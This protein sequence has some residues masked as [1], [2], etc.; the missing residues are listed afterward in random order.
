MRYAKHA[1]DITRCS[2]N[3]RL[4][5]RASP[6]TVRSEARGT[7]SPR[8]K[9]R[10]WEREP[11]RRLP[12]SRRSGASRP[13][14]VNPGEVLI[15]AVNR[16]KP[17]MLSGLDQKVRGQVQGLQAPRAR[18]AHHRPR[19]TTSPRSDRGGER[20]NPV[21]PPTREGRLRRKLRRQRRR[22]E[23]G[24][25]RRSVIDRIE[26]ESAHGRPPLA[27]KAGGLPSGVPSREDLG[28]PTQGDKQ[29][30]R[31][32]QGLLVRLPSGRPTGTPSTGRRSG[33]RSVGSRRGS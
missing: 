20:S 2:A 31:R 27:A 30:G 8:S 10:P 13:G 7:T 26:G 9:D 6:A 17:K 19:G 14:Q 25:Q 11:T 12:A 21:A 22:D 32:Q 24:S 29:I 33:A 4:P 23:G 1:S 16:G 15:K 18:M 5:R 28:Q 3:G